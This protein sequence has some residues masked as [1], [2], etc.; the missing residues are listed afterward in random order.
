[1]PLISADRAIRSSLGPIHAI[2]TVSTTNI[3]TAIADLFVDSVG[4]RNTGIRRI[5]VVNLHASQFLAIV[6]K[7]YGAAYASEAVADGIQIPPGT[8]FTCEYSA[9]LKC[10]IVGSG[11]TTTYNAVLSDL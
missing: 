5:R 9:N 2:P 6:F 7:A 3:G 1:M 8:I 11:A 4:D 10:G